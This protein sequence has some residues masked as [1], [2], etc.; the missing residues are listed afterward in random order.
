[1]KKIKSEKGITIVSLI[2]TIIILTILSS[3][4]IT[5]IKSSNNIAPYNKMIADISLL[6]DKALIYYNKYGEI[7][8][9]E[10]YITD[11][12]TT[13]YEIDLVKLD[14][15]T[16]NFGTDK[17]DETDKY[18]INNNLEVYYGK[19]TKKAGEVYHTK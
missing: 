12:G 9:T 4:A 7:P 18:F 2:M 10:N 11:K 19:G 6:E 15:I 14:N 17:T 13:Y 8:K 16:L 5:T 3:I 1:M